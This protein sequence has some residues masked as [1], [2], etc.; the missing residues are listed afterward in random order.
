M[1]R[2]PQLE[3]KETEVKTL[4][5]GVYQV[6]VYLTNT[7][8]FPTSTAQG[9]RA[10][11]VWAIRTELKLSQGQSLFSGRSMVNIPFIGGSGSTKKAEWIIKG[12]KGSKVTIS[13]GAPNLGSVTTTVVLQ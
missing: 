8:W 4:G 2:L 6:T 12:K 5:N 1:N 7:G 13:A 9:R 3:I 11:A 10:V